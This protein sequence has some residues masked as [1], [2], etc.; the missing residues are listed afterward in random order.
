MLI[1]GFH[2]VDSIYT[3]FKGQDHHRTAFYYMETLNDF[4]G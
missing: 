3:V 4:Y 1:L 2:Y